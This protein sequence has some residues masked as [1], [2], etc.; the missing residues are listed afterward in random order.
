MTKPL[1]HK[2]ILLVEDSVEIRR[3][4][5]STLERERYTVYQAEHGQAALKTLQQITP[6]LI[7]SDINMPRMNGIE[8]FKELRKNPAWTPIP[9]IFLTANNSPQDIQAGRVLGVEDYITKPID[10][11]DLISIVNARLLRVADVQVAQIGLAYLETVNVLAN[12]TEGR[13]PYTF[14]HVE[15]VAQYARRIAEALQWPPEH[16]RMLEFGARLHDIGKIMVPDEVLKKTG[17]LTDV[18]WALMKQHPVTGAKILNQI[19]HLRGTL[20]YV[21]YH[22]EKWDGTGYPRGLKGKEIPVEGRLLA[23]VDVYDAL[24]TVRPY[25][26]GRPQ[27]EVV[28]FLQAKAGVHFDP[29]MVTVFTRVL[30][31]DNK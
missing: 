7:L 24:T 9:F 29:D 10:P 2:Q 21:L 19:T 5:A 20:P 25:H 17:P 6:D 4:L 12:T 11:K 14:G 8:F 3:V 26:P 13:D 27:A 28:T 30:P 31:P 15:R 22:H 16:L 23:V 1:R 18:E